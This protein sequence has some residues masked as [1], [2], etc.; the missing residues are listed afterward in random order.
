MFSDRQCRC[1]LKILASPYTETREENPVISLLYQAMER[2]GAEIKPFTSRRL[3]FESWGVWH[4]HWPEQLLALADSFWFPLELAKFWTKL[5]IARAK[6]V[7]IFWTAHNLRPHERRH[8]LWER[9]FW[10]V[11]L[12]NVDC[13]ICMTS[14]GRD[15]L[16][17]VHPVTST[18]PIYIIPHGHY[19]GVYPDDVG[20]IEARQ[21][22]HIGQDKVVVTFIGQIRDY[23]GVPQLIRCFNAAAIP[24]SR[25]LIAGKPQNDKLD[26]EIGEAA[27]GNTD[28][29]LHLKFISAEEIQL[30]LRAAD[31]VVLPFTDILNSGSAIL[32]LSFDRPIL[33]PNLGAMGELYDML[34]PKWLRL[35]TGDLTAQTLREAIL[36]SKDM[37]AT[38]PGLAPL[39]ALSW[40]HIAMQ[41]ITAFSAPL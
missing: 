28:V 4:L 21:A 3:A 41:T 40:D 8:P 38:N 2:Q 24:A 18:R 35:Y 31:L 29:I 26:R 12:P 37:S 25:L 5:K 22:L 32:A 39:E 10:W 17:K 6:K 30:F 19:R 27:S 13:I 36:W 7:K 9:I 20:R 14:S 15:Q 34:G 33:V 1:I 23:K 11:F 16:Q